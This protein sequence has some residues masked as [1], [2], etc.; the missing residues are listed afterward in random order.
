MELVNLCEVGNLDEIKEF[1]NKNPNFDVH[2]DDEYAFQI[3]CG[4]GHLEV[5]KWLIKTFRDIDYHADNEFAFRLACEY[6]HLEVAFF[7]KKRFPDIDHHAQN[8]FCY[9]Y[10]K[11][12]EILDWLN[13]ECQFPNTTKSARKKID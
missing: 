3:A 13:H 5:A 6:G 7:L 2:Y 1:L 10:T 11:H 8:D 9:K 4:Y 12:P